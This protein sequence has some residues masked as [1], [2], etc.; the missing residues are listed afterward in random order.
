M[1]FG[2]KYFFIKNIKLHH[3]GAVKNIWFYLKKN[4]NDLHVLYNVLYIVISTYKKKLITSKYT[5]L[6]LF[7]FF[8]KNLLLSI[9]TII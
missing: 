9:I 1:I 2:H 6:K 7:N 4:I 5:V 3:F 8:W